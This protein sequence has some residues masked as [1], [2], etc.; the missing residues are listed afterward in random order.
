MTRVSRPSGS[1][2]CTAGTSACEHSGVRGWEAWE[3]IDFRL[4]D[5][6]DAGEGAV[7]L[8]WQRNCGRASAAVVEHEYTQV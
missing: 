1:I 6:M 8:I 4:D 5:L 3:S 2:R 7:A